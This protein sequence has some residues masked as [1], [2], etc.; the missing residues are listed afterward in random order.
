MVK[1]HSVNPQ[2]HNDE[3]IIEYNWHDFECTLHIYIIFIL[4][5][6]MLGIIHLA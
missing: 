5:N 1:L 6:R 3:S 4:L 2:C